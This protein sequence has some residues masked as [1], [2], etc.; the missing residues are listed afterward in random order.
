MAL[1]AAL[2]RDRLAQGCP[3]RNGAVASTKKTLLKR[4]P[5]G[6]LLLLLAG[7]CARAEVSNGEGGE[8]WA[9]ARVPQEFSSSDLIGVWTSR[10]GAATDR[11]V[12]QKD[13][14]YSQTYVQESDGYSFENSGNEWRLESRASGGHYLHLG[15]M[16]RCDNTGELCS[17]PSGGGG[18]FWYWDFCEDRLV[19]MPG[20]V[21]LLVTGARPGEEPAPRGVIL[22][23]MAADPDS[24]SFSF[25]L[26]SPAADGSNSLSP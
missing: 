24:G 6:W 21:I 20:E 17:L 7:A 3:F 19:R 16:R 14:T 1:G 15:A 13:G 5:L 4:L 8:G 9:C 11:L 2:D 10:Y 26:D 18:E 25:S 22:W 12:L 23:H